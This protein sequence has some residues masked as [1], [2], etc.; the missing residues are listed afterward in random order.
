[1]VLTELVKTTK[2]ENLDLQLESWRWLRQLK[3]KQK[4]RE[5]PGNH[6]DPL[7]LTGWAK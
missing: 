6:K 3:T 5:A 2:L 7:G 4:Q 1:M